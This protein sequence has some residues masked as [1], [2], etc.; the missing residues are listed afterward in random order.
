MSFGQGGIML[1]HAPPLAIVACACLVLGITVGSAMPQANAQ[2]ARS[3]NG[4]GVVEVDTRDADYY[5]NRGNAF[6][7]NK[8][9]DKAIADYNK[10]I[11]LD[12]ENGYAYNSRADTL[13]EAGKAAQG[14]PDAEKALQLDSNN[15]EFWD[16]RAQI[17]AA[18]GRREEAI[19]D[20]RRAL[21]LDPYM[22]GSLE[23]LK[24]LGASP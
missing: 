23:R 11:E 5:V 15:A 2:S 13:R 6:A 21:A 14:L 12:P 9:Y 4:T 18:V 17:F 19:A 16:T 7:D 22:A 20:Y 10:A 3:N 1:G 8:D 24:R